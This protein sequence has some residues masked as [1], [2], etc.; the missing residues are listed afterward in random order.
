ML[1]MRLF[2]H[3]PTANLWHLFWPFTISKKKKFN[4]KKVGVVLGLLDYTV[5]TDEPARHVQ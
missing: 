3:G 2:Q 1:I 5:A 4:I